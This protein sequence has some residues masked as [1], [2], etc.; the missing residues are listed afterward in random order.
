MVLTITGLIE[1]QKLEAKNAEAIA[2]TIFINYGH[3]GVDFARFVMNKTQRFVCRQNRESQRLILKL[4]GDFELVPFET[5][6]DGL[7]FD[8]LNY[9]SCW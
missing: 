3:I 1:I 6:E 2:K 7:A 9:V 5:E 8:K 4:N